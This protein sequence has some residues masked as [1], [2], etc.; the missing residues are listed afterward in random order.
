M[1][2][3]KDAEGREWEVRL[4][5]GT[6]IRVC[7]QLD[8]KLSDFASL[9]IAVADIIDSLPIVCEEQIKA[10]GL[11]REEFLDGMGMAEMNAAIKAFMA[12]ARGDFP[13]KQTSGKGG[14][15]DSSPLD[16]GKSETS[17]N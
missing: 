5:G 17:G 10:R 14:G 13:D 3:F 6:L 2:S 9:S 7:R 12:A 8:L 4:R 16:P 1:V 11:T 15:K